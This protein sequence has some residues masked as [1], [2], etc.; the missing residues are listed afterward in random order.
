MKKLLLAATLISTAAL[1]ASAAD[2]FYTKGTKLYDAKDNEFI[3]RGVNYAW[4][5]QQGNENSVIPAAK[6]IGCN[7]VR[8]AVRFNDGRRADA[9]KLRSLIKLC[10]DN[11]LAVVLEDHAVTGST[12]TSDLMACVNYWKEMTSVLN[13]NLDIVIVNIANE[14]Y[15][16]WNQAQAWA[17]GYIQAIKAMRDAG[18]KNTLMVDAAGYGQ[19]PAS[20]NQKGK[21]VAAADKLHNIMFSTHIYDD[22]GKDESTT[23]QSIDYTLAPGVPAVIGEF[24]YKHKG[25][26]VCYQT[27]MDYCQQKGIGYLVWSWTGNSS[28]V[29]DCDMFADY[30]ANNYKQNG[31]LTVKGKNGIQA[32]SKELSVFNSTPSGDNTGGNTGDNTGEGGI[33]DTYTPASP[34]AFGNWNAEINIPASFFAKAKA[35]DTVRMTFSDCGTNPQVQIVTKI[36]AEWTWTEVVPYA[37]IANNNYEYVLPESYESQDIVSIFAERG[38]ILKGQNA[39]LTKAELISNGSDTPDNTNEIGSWA[40]ESSIDFNGWNKEILIPGSTFAK[41]SLGDV[42]RL[43]FTECGATPQVQVI[44]KLGEGW[45]WTELVKSA[46]IVAEVYEYTIAELAEKKATR[47]GNDVNTVLGALKEHGMILK[48]QQAKLAKVSVVTTATPSSVDGVEIEDAEAPVEIYNLQGVRVN[49]MTKG[50]YILRQGNKVTKV[51]K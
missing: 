3:M 11:K 44:V 2:G 51:I 6:Q 31:T 40:P 37:D 49:E 25:R 29:A 34:K 32:T 50:I 23:R 5:W 4:V 22:A 17:D 24:A 21:D 19:W 47:A 33:K 12:S 35:G 10:R 9:S 48:G 46:D 28:E 1:G 42:V 26:N 15:G 27:V 8:L 38:M 30:T 39:T 41:A 14:W 18:I 20:V 43:Q 7:T 36:G 16:P 45:T 13:D